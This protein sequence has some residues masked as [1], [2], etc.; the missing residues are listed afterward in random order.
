[1]IND[2]RNR[3]GLPNTTATDKA[4]FQIAIQNERL[5]EFWAEAERRNDLIRWGLFIQRAINDGFTTVD[6]H[7]ILFPLPR[8]VV[9][10][11]NGVIAQ[12]PGYN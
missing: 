6:N 7:L 11:S 10:Q 5:F 12:N 8:T 1:M 4:S 2:V 3:A 9:T